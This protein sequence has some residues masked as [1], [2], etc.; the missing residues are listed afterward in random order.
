MSE[1]FGWDSSNRAVGPEQTEGGGQRRR[2]PTLAW[3]STGAFA[4]IVLPRLVGDAGRGRVGACLGLARCGCSVESGRSSSRASGIRRGLTGSAPKL[5]L[6][7]CREGMRVGLLRDS[8]GGRVGTPARCRRD[9]GA[10]AETRLNGERGRGVSTRQRACIR[11]PAVHLQGWLNGSP[12]IASSRCSFRQSPN[13]PLQR[14]T[15]LLV[16][17]PSPP[18]SQAGA[19]ISSASWTVRASDSKVRATQVPP[20]PADAAQPAPCRVLA[21]SLRVGDL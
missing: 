3:M 14:Q 18:G 9:L 19:Q 13:S 6:G 21:L 4:T 20:R 7:G 15:T 17:P 8:A 1:A 11:R 2:G 5:M 10:A 12:L 16:G